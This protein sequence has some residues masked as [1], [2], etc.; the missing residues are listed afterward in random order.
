[1]V[2][3]FSL[4]ESYGINPKQV[5]LARHSNKEIDVQQTFH[6]NIE[7]LTSYQ[8]FQRPNKFADAKYLAAFCPTT[9]T[10]A[11]FLGVWHI[12]LQTENNAWGNE[13]HD[14]INR[15][16]FPLFWHDELAH[17]KLIP[18]DIMSDLAERVVIEWGGATVQWLQSINKDVVEIRR[19]EA[20]N[21]FVSFDQVQL[22][23]ADLVQI[24]KNPQSNKSWVNTLSSV[25]GVYLITDTSSGKMYVGSAYGENGIYGRWSTYAA[26]G[27]GGNQ[28]LKSLDPASFVF[29]ILEI[30]PG[31]MSADEV[32]AR[33]NRWKERLFTRA[34]GLNKN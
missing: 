32:I 10:E 24:T 11:L 26:T 13:L 34:F 28:E 3:F 20:I 31:T 1:M 23:F 21:E 33:E 30:A 8:S 16:G 25:N 27:H 4:L 12:G 7:K 29:S 17:Y 22:A 6:E 9:G 14:Q 18:S 2:T 15:Y 19:A 5:R